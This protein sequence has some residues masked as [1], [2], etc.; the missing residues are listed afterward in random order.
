MERDLK[1]SNKKSRKGVFVQNSSV[2]L[3]ESQNQSM[4]WCMGWLNYRHKK[5]AEI[6]GLIVIIGG[7]TGI[8][9]LDRLLTYA[10]FQDRCIQPLCHPSGLRVHILAAFLFKST[11]FSTNVTR[12]G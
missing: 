5:A 7:G 12:R 10:G 11:P 8:R 1:A 4:G 9:T 3:N 6:S 2:L